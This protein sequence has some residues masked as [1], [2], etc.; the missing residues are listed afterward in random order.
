MPTTEAARWVWQPDA[1]K[2]EQWNGPAPAED[3][4]LKTEVERAK[5]MLAGSSELDDGGAPYSQATL[6][7]AIAFV[8]VHSAKGHSLCGYYP[9]AP[10]IGLGPDGSIDLHWKQSKWELLVNV[11]SDDSQVAV[12]YGDDYGVAKIRG[13]FD[14]KTVN[15]GI[16]NWL[17]H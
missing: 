16:V 2:I 9:P 4:E 7:R 13:S 8:R 14:P 10:R 5:G 3:V 15:L 1:D 6:D 11:P 17:M 12:F